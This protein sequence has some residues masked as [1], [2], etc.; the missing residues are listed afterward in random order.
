[1]LPNRIVHNIRAKE[2]LWHVS[3]FIF[4]ITGSCTGSL[5]FKQQRIVPLVSRVTANRLLSDEFQKIAAVTGI[6]Y[7]LCGAWRT[8]ATGT[9]TKKALYSCF[10]GSLFFIFQ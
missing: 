2:A 6:N 5:L 7:F 3:D 1:L 8:L 10:D 4:R 9:I